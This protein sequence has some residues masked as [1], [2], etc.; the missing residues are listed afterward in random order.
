MD[1]YQFKMDLPAA[2][3][4]VVV[5]LTASACCRFGLNA[6]NAS[7]ASVSV[8]ACLLR[9][10]SPLLH[11]LPQMSADSRTELCT[12]AICHSIACGHSYMPVM[13]KSNQRTPESKNRTAA[14][15]S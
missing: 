3:A 15:E 4:V 13:A 7:N 9:F 12:R 10:S 1:I 8:Q 14:N 5:L 11:I 6:S 2:A